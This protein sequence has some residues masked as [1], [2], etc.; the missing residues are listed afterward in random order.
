MVNRYKLLEGIAK[1]DQ[2]GYFKAY[3]TKLERN[4]IIKLVLHSN[5]YSE[6]AIDY[7]LSES[8][9]LAKLA[10]PNIAKVLDFGLDNKN[11]YLVSEYTPGTP[12]SALMNGPM[13]WKRAAEILIPL[14]DGLNYAHSR[15]IIHRD[16]NPENVIITED[17]RLILN[18]F[19]L[20]KMIED[21]ETREMTG[22]KVGL[23]SPAYISPEQ[24]KGLPAD[25]RSDIYSLGVIFYEM[26]TGQK[27]F[28]NGSPMDIVIQHVTSE[29][30]RPKKII[31]SLPDSVEKIIITAL[32]KDA[33]KRYQSMQDFSKALEAVLT[34]SP[35]EKNRGRTRF[36]KASTPWVALAFILIFIAF[37]GYFSWR[38]IFL[39]S[40]LATTPPL[41]ERQD[42]EIPLATLA[43]GSLISPVTVQPT[44]ISTTESAN[45]VDVN[46]AHPG[47]VID[48]NTSIARKENTRIY[49]LSFIDHDSMVINGT[50]DGLYFYDSSDLS[51]KYF[52]DAKG[53]VSAIATSD[54]GTWIATGDLNGNAAIWNVKDGSEIARFEGLSGTPVSLD[55][56]PDKSKLA[57]A[58]GNNV[59]VWDLIKKTLLF[60]K[61]HDLPVNKVLF[62]HDGKYV[63]SA[64]DDYQIMFYD[65]SSGDFS[66]KYSANQKINDFSISPDNSTMVL[67]L[68]DASIEIRSYN[69]GNLINSGINDPEIKDPY[70]FSKFL[71]INSLITIGS[72]NGIVQIRNINGNKIWELPQ[73]ENKIISLRSLATSIDG[74]RIA[75]L[76]E[77]NVVTVWNLSE[78]TMVASK[79]LSFVPIPNTTTDNS[80]RM[81]FSFPALPVIQGTEI[82]K[83]TKNLDATNI[84]EISELARWGNPLI[85]DISFVDNSRMIM[86]AT[87]AG[88]YFYETTDL[89]PK[90][91]FDTT[92]WLTAFSLSQD[93][94]WVATGDKNGNLAVWNLSD[95]KQIALIEGQ[96]PEIISVAISPDKTLL[97]SV[98]ENK[99]ISI[100]DIGTQKLKFSLSKHLHAFRV[101]KLLFS[102]DGKYVVSGGDDFKL[103]LWDVNTGELFREYSA[104][105]KINDLSISPDGKLVALALNNSKIEILNFDGDQNRKL[106]E[107]PNKIV[108]S[109]TSIK[110]LPSN[111]LLV[112]GSENGIVRIWNIN[113]TIVWESS[114]Q[115]MDGSPINQSTIKSIALSD[116]GSKIATL[117]IDNS[118]NVWDNT[119]KVLLAS[120]Q[121][122]YG[123]INHLSISTDDKLLVDQSGDS[124]IQLWSI[125]N[126]KQIASI[127]GASLPRG[128]PISSNREYLVTEA[129]NNLSL[130]SLQTGSPVLISLLYGFPFDGTVNYLMEDKIIATAGKGSFKYWS[131]SSGKELTPSVAPK[132]QGFCQILASDDGQFIAAFSST[133]ILGNPSNVNYYCAT[134][135]S[136]RTISEDFLKDGSIIALS[137]EN[138]VLEVWDSK[139]NNQKI[140]INS[141]A[142]GDMNDVAIS[143]DGKL[144]AA[145]SASGVIEIYDLASNT[146]V[147]TISGHSASV[148]Q[149]L[150]TND[151]KYIISAST[152]GTVRFWG[153]TK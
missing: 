125:E 103:K 2:I 43:P 74:T 59:Y 82:P 130:Y 90:Y 96:S 117:S 42:T 114:G 128:N 88:I 28:P 97:A 134:T 109:F 30:P 149:V 102:P 83:A 70:K 131:I 32:S 99:I 61:K 89:S 72:G 150:F 56:S 18:D 135:R 24:G 140:T 73:K 54:D 153:I 35:L 22:T 19:S 37:F 101:N 1:S 98:A 33:E 148:T 40:S 141:Q 124:N 9:A 145:A 132:N 27:P 108:D 139:I 85:S 11:L 63:I 127:D 38:N 16:L 123:Q 119:G 129:N 112:S 93:G 87:S 84:K 50:N 113:G 58:S 26:V 95:G 80:T 57:S 133:G 152:D 36:L 151:L 142:L 104:D 116:D 34:D 44:I 105:K 17:G 23:G 20:I 21:E 110:F 3:D 118:I 75:T 47:I 115:N 91:F 45:L 81:I 39:P 5:E 52:L 122:H 46:T 106:F 51:L 25:F 136:P 69:D 71:P 94:A 146:L 6:E 107:A 100:W 120:K 111:S 10:H 78:R 8:R 49:S 55:F 65:V 126:Y 144:I 41:A 121:L 60:V 62:S 79:D 12:L 64:G 31:P 143:L 13:D 53:P 86:A 137:L 92:G 15:G 4:V 76:S 77:D 48:S 66:K 138:Q 7:F 147:D 29:P 68:N 67:A 14:I